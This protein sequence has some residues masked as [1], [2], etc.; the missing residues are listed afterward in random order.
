MSSQ[1]MENS[2]KI[3]DKNTEC[4]IKSSPYKLYLFTCIIAFAL[5]LISTIV[6][7]CSLKNNQERIVEQQQMCCDSVLHHFSQL[8]F[9]K[10]KT[11][12]DSL[13]DVSIQ[14]II[15]D[16]SLLLR[17]Q[18]ASSQ[19]TIEFQLET[20]LHTIQHEY[21]ILSLWAAL[22]MIV[23]LVFSFYSLYKVDDILKQG[24]EGLMQCR[25]DVREIE[26]LTKEAKEKIENLEKSISDN[27]ESYKNELKKEI[28]SKYDNIK[29]KLQV[30]VDGKWSLIQEK[31]V[32]LEDDIVK[33]KQMQDKG[34]DEDS[35]P[36]KEQD[37]SSQKSEK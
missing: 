27:V 12:K 22:L 25:E 34:T 10:S 26:N 29:M 13:D 31:F 15:V 20:Q 9:A 2:E 36:D 14:K 11:Y 30:D 35:D 24:R 1:S 4:G 37:E 33:I 7:C 28:D 21:L 23:F 32:A 3:R 6:S 17:Q 18:L 8:C 5:L 19:K 16:D